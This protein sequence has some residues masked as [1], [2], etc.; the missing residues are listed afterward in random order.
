MPGQEA[1]ESLLRHAVLS[2][3]LEARR[4]A[5]ECLKSRLPQDYVPI[6]LAG[7]AMPVESDVDIAGSFNGLGVEI[8]RSVRKFADRPASSLQSAAAMPKSGA[9]G[10]ASCP[11]PTP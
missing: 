7:L 10:P 1:T 8:N 2:R 11:S 6:L 3:W 9:R 4:A 5:I